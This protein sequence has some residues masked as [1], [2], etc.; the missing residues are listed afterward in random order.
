MR[1]VPCIDL[2]ERSTTNK[3]ARQLSTPRLPLS[4]TWKLVKRIPMIQVFQRTAASYSQLCWSHV[5]S[6]H[7]PAHC[8]LNHFID[9]SLSR[10]THPFLSSSP[11]LFFSFFSSSTI[12]LPR[13]TWPRFHLVAARKFYKPLSN[14]IYLGK[15]PQDFIFWWSRSAPLSFPIV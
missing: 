4:W 5:N 6:L 1:Y 9:F 8:L 12:N 7:R 2:C 3:V 13:S 14:V 11:L 10:P 15:L